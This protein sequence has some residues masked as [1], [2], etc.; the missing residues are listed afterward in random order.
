MQSKLS[1]A[2]R[3]AA[4]LLPIACA[5]GGNP[6]GT[7]GGGGGATSGATN[8]GSVN[9]G[10]SDGGKA[11]G[12][13]GAAGASP[14]GVAGA[15]G[16]GAL[17]VPAD[18]PN[19]PR[20]GDPGGGLT[21]L[22][23][24]LVPG[25]DGPKLYTAVKNEGDRPSCEAGVTTDFFD[26]SG[27]QVASAGSALQGGRFYRLESGNVIRCIDPGQIAM[28]ASTELREDIVIADLGHLSHAFPAFVMEG[29][30]AVEGLNVE[31]VMPVAMISGGAYRGKLSNGFDVSVS[32]PRVTI[33][34]LN[35][36]GRPLGV[37][38]SSGTEDVPAGG[39]WTFE[40]S[41]VSSLGVDYAAYPT[42]SVPN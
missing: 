1:F 17:F 11:G 6:G 42:A 32:A 36:V 8:G 12:N 5:D 34:P 30:T 9:A 38:T 27:Q 4:F 7:G 20:E 31:E 28:A 39:S 23:F 16:D 14:G 15:V 22:S 21:L 18:L 33:F 37:A 19:M 40:T 10:G 24:T 41:S 35:R 3:A 26:K 13:S 25:N 2:I 29:I